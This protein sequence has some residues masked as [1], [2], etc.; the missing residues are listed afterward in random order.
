MQGREL[1][2]G[3]TFLEGTAGGWSSRLF[4]KVLSGRGYSIKAAATVIRLKVFTENENKATGFP[5]AAMWGLVWL[6]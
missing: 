3:S 1:R 4:Q 5:A 6:A 2:C